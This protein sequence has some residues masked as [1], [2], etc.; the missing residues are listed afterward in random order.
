MGRGT[1]FNVMIGPSSG[2]LIN[3]GARFAGCMKFI[4]GVSDTSWICLQDSNSG[5]VNSRQATCSSPSPS[6]SPILPLTL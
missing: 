4:P 5:I 2:V 1:R 6:S 3:S